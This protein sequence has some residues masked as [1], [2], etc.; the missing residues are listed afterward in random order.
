[1]PASPLVL[2]IDVGTSSARALLFDARGRAV[3]G[4]EGRTPYA[5]RTTPDGGAELDPEKL[6]RDTAGAVDRVLRAKTPGKIIGVAVSTFW[7]SVMG[8][9]KDGAPLTP[10]YTWADTRS[11]HARLLRERLDEKA[12]HARTGCMFHASYL[13]AKLLWIAQTRPDVF[14]R[15][16]RW[17]S[18]GEYLALRLFGRTAASY[19]MASATGLFNQQTAAW[20]E[21]VLRA[22][23]VS[24]EQLSPLVD[25]DQAFGGLGKTWARRWPRLRDAPWTPAV[26]DGACNNLG[27][28]AT[29]RHTAAVMV[30]TSGALRVVWKG[31]PAPIPWGLFCY[32]ATLDR[33][34]MG[35]A[36]SN[37]GNLIDWIRRTFR[38]GTRDE[39]AVAA[40]EPDSGGLT[41]LPFLAGER[42]PG[43]ALDAHGMLAGLRLHTRPGHVLRA[44]ME[45]VACRFALIRE[46]LTG[47]RGVVASGGAL[48]NSPAWMQILA[49]A[50]G[51]PIRASGEAEASAR[52]AA[53]LTLEALKLVPRLEDLPASIGRGFVPDESRHARYGVALE[54]QRRLYDLVI[55]S[56]T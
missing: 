45:A 31:S 38:L 40:M 14:R 23:S 48:L 34:V 22:V 9:G 27:S 18:F 11:T 4:R 17:M 8:V 30:G 20:D 37:G 19:S 7:H 12:V 32:R 52:G 25:V 21:E 41:F 56:R 13:P 43:W 6:L 39:K 1:M 44:G 5:L 16:A 47:V 51:C 42:S 10:V 24:P 2:T 28:G 33:Y 46:L 26:G 3:K 36:L 55:G 35:G 49:D 15:A 54:R 53:L 50:L 29:D